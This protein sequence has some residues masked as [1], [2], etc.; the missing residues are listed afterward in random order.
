MEHPTAEV[1]SHDKSSQHYGIQINFKKLCLTK[2]VAQESTCQPTLFHV[3]LEELH[4][5]A[6]VS[7]LLLSGFKKYTRHTQARTLWSYMAVIFISGV[8]E[9]KR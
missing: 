5:C 9:L 6:D 1:L 4:S 8:W 3:S 2:C 7:M